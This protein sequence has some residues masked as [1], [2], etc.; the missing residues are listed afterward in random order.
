M[1]LAVVPLVIFGATSYGR[2]IKRLSKRYQDQLAKAAD[3]SQEAIS[4]VGGV[5]N[6]FR[7]ICV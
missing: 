1:A 3:V 4:N 7:L 5:Q 2:Y 6:H